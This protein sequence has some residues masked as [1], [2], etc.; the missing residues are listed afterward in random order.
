MKTRLEIWLNNVQDTKER[1]FDYK[2]K[3]CESPKNRI[4]PKGLT[5]CFG[6]K[7]PILSLFAFGQNKARNKVK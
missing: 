1:L 4:L 5:H 6:Q 3:I 2:R 7:L